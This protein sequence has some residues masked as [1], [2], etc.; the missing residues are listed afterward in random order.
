MSRRLAVRPAANAFD[1]LIQEG[2]SGRGASAEVVGATDLAVDF[3]H[4][5]TECNAMEQPGCEAGVRIDQIEE[6]R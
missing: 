6:Y 3:L 5:E 1:H 2:A 4:F